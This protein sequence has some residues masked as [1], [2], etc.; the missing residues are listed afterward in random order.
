MTVLILFQLIILHVVASQGSFDP[1]YFDGS[2][3]V[4]NKNTDCSTKTTGTYPNCKCT[5]KFFD[6]STDL[7]YCFRV[8]TGYW[9]N[10]VCK[11]MPVSINN[12]LNVEF[13]QLIVKTV[14]FTR[15]VIA[16]NSELII[17]T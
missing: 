4:N 6:Y 17:Y 1:N 9:P 12:I 8:C 3:A 5:A 14:P 13:V 7:N 2:D 15:I 10:C 11:K 16:A